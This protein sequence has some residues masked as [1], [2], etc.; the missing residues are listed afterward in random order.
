MFAAVGGINVIIDCLLNVE[1]FLSNIIR[2]D[3]LVHSLLNLIDDPKTRQY[4]RN[5]KDID[6]IF[7]IFT[8]AD[9]VDKEPKADALEKLQL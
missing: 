2:Y 5:Y 1:L 7:S 3:I 9:G 8:Q 4:L 6:R